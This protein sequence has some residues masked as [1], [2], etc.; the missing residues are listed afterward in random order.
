MGQE[1]IALFYDRRNARLVKS[2]ELMSTNFVEVYMVADSEEFR[3]GEWQGQDKHPLYYKE[4][5][6]GSLGY[7]SENCPEHS[8]WDLYCNDTDL[9]FIRMENEEEIDK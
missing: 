4:R 2:G 3:S 8:N 5:Q 7:R 9:V 1:M 6:V